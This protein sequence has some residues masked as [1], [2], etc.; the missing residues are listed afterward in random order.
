[1]KPSL[2]VKHRAGRFFFHKENKNNQPKNEGNL[3]EK[4]ALGSWMV[5]APFETP[6]LFLPF[7]RS[8]IEDSRIFPLSWTPGG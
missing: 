3:M 2:G 5:E 7:V 6:F 4:E 1:M 8:K